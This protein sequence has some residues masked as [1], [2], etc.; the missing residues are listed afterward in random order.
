MNKNIL[1]ILF[2]KFFIFSCMPLKET[3]LFSNSNR[4]EANKDEI[5]L[6]GNVVISAIASASR[7]MHDISWK[8]MKANK[9]YCNEGRINAFGIMVASSRDL[10]LDL[11]PSFLAASPYYN[12]Y[13]KNLKDDLAMIVSVAEES[14]AD[15]AGLKE[16]DF[17]LSING[18]N[19]TINSYKKLLKVAAENNYLELTILRNEETFNFSLNSEITCGYP[20]QPMISPIPNAYADGSKIFITIA[21]LDF[22]KDD[23]ELAFLIGHELAHNIVHYKG[24]GMPEAEALPLPINDN[25]IIRNISDVFIFQS[26]KKEMEA[27]ML[28]VEYVL[29][30]G[31][32]QDKAADYFRRLSIYMPVLM[33]DSIFRMHPGNIKRAVEIENKVKSY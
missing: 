26:G 29:R 2:I 10:D 22:I 7:K 3:S 12:I 19:Y 24:K 28:G 9:S 5:I 8:I 31:I 17:I 13:S 21:T 18:N 15:R 1:I 30:A 32:K 6:Q 23:Q 20:V 16:G 4:E 11:R 27:D 33:K 25:P 14:P